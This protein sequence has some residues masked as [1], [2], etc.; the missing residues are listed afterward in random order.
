M[1]NPTK[2]KLG[3]FLIRK[4]CYSVIMT[5]WN[6]SQSAKHGVWFLLPICLVRLPAG[7]HPLCP[8]FFPP[9]PLMS[10]RS[11]P[12]TL[13]SSSLWFHLP[14]IIS[15]LKT[16]QEVERDP[17]CMGKGIIGYESS[18]IR[19]WLTWILSQFLLGQLPRPSTLISFIWKM[20]YLP[21]QV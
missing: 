5:P 1:K 16:E 12:H 20:N 9:C 6:T 21:L 4:G 7:G 19:R 14:R 10:I 8:H 2:C 3:L 17:V 13:F 15:S 18:G 11:N